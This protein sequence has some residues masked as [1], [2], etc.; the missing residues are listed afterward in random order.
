MDCVVIHYSEIGLK[1]KN[2][3]Y[4][5]KR[6]LNNIKKK[7]G[8]EVKR[9]YGRLVMVYDKNQIRLLKKVPGIAYYSPALRAELD[10]KD[11]IK[12]AESLVTKGSFR[13]TA[14]RSNKSFKPNSIEINKKVGEALYNKGLKVELEKP[15]TEVFIEVGNKNAYLYTKKVKGL[16]GLPVGVTG[17][18]VALVSGGIDSPVACYEMIR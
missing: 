1:G 5:E 10:L 7:T 13:I 4:F 9:E 12:K 6:L 2:R 17:K 8:L 18:L 11:F 15:D 3:P 14:K 16:G